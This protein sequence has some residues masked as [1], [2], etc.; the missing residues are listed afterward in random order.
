[1]ADVCTLGGVTPLDLN[2][3]VK[4]FVLYGVDLGALKTEYD[5]VRAYSGTIRQVDVHQPLVEVVIPMKAVGTGATDNDKA[6]DLQTTLELIRAQCIAGGT[7]TWTPEGEPAGQTFAVGP[8]PEPEVL[9]DEVYKLRH[10][11]RFELHLHRMP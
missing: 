2:T 1:V 6:N 5:E 4:T 8:S 7:L 3:R 10:V 11:A 9:L